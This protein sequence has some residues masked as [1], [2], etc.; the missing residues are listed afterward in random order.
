MTLDL[1]HTINNLFSKHDTFV[2]L[3]KSYITNTLACS[4][5]MLASV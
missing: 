5:V 4:G 3:L 2:V 1:N